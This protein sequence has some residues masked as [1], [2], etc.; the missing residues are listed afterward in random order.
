MKRFFK[1]AAAAGLSLLIAAPAMATE[2]RINSLSGN[3]KRFTVR[4]Q[5]NI[6]GLPQFLVDYGNQVDVDTMG[7]GALNG[8]TAW[9][10]MNIRYSL[11]DDAVLMINAQ[12]TKW[13]DVVNRQTPGGIDDKGAAQKGVTAAGLAGYKHGAD[14]PTHHQFG[15]GFGMRMGE[16]ARLGAGFQIGGS[17]R[18]NAATNLEN[19]TWF[20]FNA[21]FGLDLGETDSIDLGL[22]LGFGSFVN[23]VKN[24]DHYLNNGLLQITL[25]AKGEFT[26][27]Q[28]AAIV[29][30][31][32]FTYD[33]RN[34]GHAQADVCGTGEAVGCSALQGTT[35]MTDTRFGVDLAIKPAE[36]VLVQ[37]GLGLAIASVAASGNAAKVAGGTP[38]RD[39]EIGS[40][41]TPFYGFAAE[42]AAFDWLKLRVGARQHI[43]TRINDN[44]I[45]ADPN[46]PAQDQ[47][48]N[49]RH[50]SDVENVLTTGFGISLRGWTIDLNV[51]PDFFNNNVY[52]VSGSATG[53][54]G[55]D[56]AILY[57]W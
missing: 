41:L 23:V 27:H 56:F 40:V 8:G 29:P 16:A 19:N 9:G 49:Q 39:F 13:S 38:P 33:S 4:D 32:A 25:L 43:V 10:K 28:I 34:V 46:L 31:I 55:L 26:V 24:G 42:A 18:D 5:A 17:R 11:T 44:T 22:N 35:A 30:F 14:D 1:V 3:E 7:K 50:W 2:T 51:N 48:S 47:K 21:G 37:P 6:Y 15:L 12:G 52:A 54:F 45:P 57:E 20:E 36:G 53:N